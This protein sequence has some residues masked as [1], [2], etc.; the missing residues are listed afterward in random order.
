[1]NINELTLNSMIGK[2]VIIRTYSAGNWFGLL[3]QKAGNEVIIK[4]ARRMRRWK[5]SKSITLSGVARYGIDQEKSKIVDA[6]DAVWLEAIEIIPC[7]EVAIKSI[8]GAGNVEA[9]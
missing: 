3:D 8:G 9:Q 1:M 7:T 2:H 6:V 5:A 4:N